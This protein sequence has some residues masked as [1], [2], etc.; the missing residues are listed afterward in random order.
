MSSVLFVWELGA[1]MGHLAQYRA[2]AQNLTQQGH[3]VYFALR[4]VSKADLA[5][6]GVTVRVLQAPVKQQVARNSAKLSLSYVHILQNQFFDH[7]PTLNSAVSA[8]RTM[9]DLIKPD[10]VIAD[11]SP[12]ALVALRGL[13]IRQLIL[14]TGFL[15]P[16]DTY[17]LTNMR[18]WMEIDVAALRAEEDAM[19]QTVNAVLTKLDAPNLQ[20]LGELFSNPNELAFRTY[21]EVDHYAPRPGANYYGLISRYPGATP[22]WPT[23]PNKKIFAY[24]KPFEHLPSLLQNLNASRLPTLIVPDEIPEDV[25]QRF[26]SETLKFVAEPLDLQ[27]VAKECD[28]AITNG[29]HATTMELIVSGVPVV[30][31]PLHLEQRLMSLRLET[32]GAGLTLEPEKPEEFPHCLNKALN[33]KQLIAG[34]RSFA[35][36]YKDLDPIAQGEKLFARIIELINTPRGEPNPKAQPTGITATVPWKNSVAVLSKS[37]DGS[38]KANVVSTAPPPPAPNLPTPEARAAN[39]QA[40]QQIAAAVKLHQSGQI[41]QAAQIYQAV[42]QENPFE[43]NALHMLGVAALQLNQPQKAAELIGRAIALRPAEASFHCNQGEAFRR[44]GQFDTAA[45]CFRAALQYQPRYAEAANN[46]GL[47]LEAQGNLAEARAGYETALRYNPNFAQALNNLANVLRRSGDTE[48]ALAYFRKAAQADPNFVEAHSNL[49]QLLLEEFQYEEARTYCQ[50]A[51]E[52]DPGFFP[53]R[54]NLGNVLRELGRIADA[55]SCYAEALRLNPNSALTCNNIAQAFQEEGDLAEAF[56]WY[57]RAVQQDPKSARIYTNVASLMRELDRNGEAAALFRKA[58]ETDPSYVEAHEGLASL[59]LE[60]GRHAEAEAHFREAIRIQPTHA[61]AFVGL[62]EYYAELGKMKDAES[63]LRNALHLRRFN[64]SASTQLAML[65][66]GK[67]SADDQ[68]ALE[69]YLQSPRLT[70]FRRAPLQYALAHVL[71]GKGQYE[72]A[73]GLLREANATSTRERARRGRGYDPAEHAALVSELIGIFTPEFLARTSGFGSPSARPIF[74]LGLPRS[75]TTLTEQILASHKKVHGAGELSFVRASLQSLPAVMNSKESALR[76]LSQITPEAA[77]IVARG[78]LERLAAL[79]SSAEHVVDKMPENYL[80]IGL[81]ALLFPNA[82]IIHC[83]RDLRDIAVS[84][85]MTNF[86]HIRWATNEDAIASHIAQYQRIMAHWRTVLPGRFLDVDYEATVA[87]LEGSARK[88]LA[89]ANLEWDP[90]CL[91]FHQ[92]DRVVRTAS[93]TQVREPIHQRSVE[94]WRKYEPALGAL[95][96]KLS[97]L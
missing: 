94:R 72:R 18:L 88:L 13:G 17:P 61:S 1:G 45:Q 43:P 4:D 6:K 69:A 38:V 35:A 70:P 23:A 46:L 92:T 82:K 41:Q 73:A 76:C 33:S 83:R 22:E 15:I 75:G 28:L 62:G 42:L 53:A 85:W 11:H 34:A 47:V 71:D 78:H 36:K 19:L 67:L 80:Y 29:N 90:A 87:D 51:V 16:P 54:N 74:V 56:N 66:R 44:L 63:C 50:R 55:K 39:V 25:I 60:D 52:L 14:G 24:L 2:L 95:F 10:L 3:S 97:P 31:A 8:W 37:D 49:G 58:L 12:T 9:F 59:L 5:F 96:A 21:S 26:R 30:T 91:N 32:L 84:C 93:I 57:Q 64:P 68:A 65:H 7:E 79:N 48:G 81:I 20:R 27:R 77:Q 89:F 40:G 86:R